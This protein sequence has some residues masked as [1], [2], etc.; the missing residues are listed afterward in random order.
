MRLYRRVTFVCLTIWCFRLPDTTVAFVGAGFTAAEHARAFG[1]L[2][3]EV[4]LAGLTTRTRERG[5]SL[6]AQVGIPAV[7]DSIDQLYEMTRADLVVLCVSEESMEDVAR[8]AFHFPW[9]VLMEKPPGYNHEVA[10][11][12]AAEASV[13][14]SSVYVALNRRFYETIRQMKSGL[15]E[16]GGSRRFIQ[17]NDQQDRRQAQT[18]GRP[19][20]VGQFWMYPA[21]IHLIDL[22]RVLMRGKIADVELVVPWSDTGDEPVVALVEAESGDKAVYQAVWGG[23]GPWAVAAH[24]GDRRWEAR[25]LEQLTHQRLGFP[26]ERLVGPDSAS[27]IK[28]GF[29]AQAREAILAARGRPNGSVPLADAIETMDLIRRI[30]A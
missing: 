10:C 11:R 21:S 14:S 28:A 25:P 19:P 30:Y 13:T 7:Y 27:P 3:S 5:V 17:V 16:C 23:P 20:D 26:A 1:A 15:D 4:Q 24:A 29:E 12:I 6:A 2:G 9:T 8:Q 18:L 22:M